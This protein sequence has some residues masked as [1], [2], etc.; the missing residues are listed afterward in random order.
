MGGVTADSRGRSKAFVVV[1]PVLLLALGLV[2]AYKVNAVPDDVVVT[3]VT[4]SAGAG[5][6]EVTLPAGSTVNDALTAAMVEPVDGRLLSA[7]T[8]RVLH[9]DLDP[10]RI[11]LDG[12]PVGRA[13]ALMAD[14]STVKVVNGRDETEKTRTVEEEVAAPPGP[15]VLRLVEERGAP[16]RVRRVVGVTSGEEVSVETVVAARA[17]A[18][19]TQKVVA[20]TFD[21]G[22]S[23]KWTPY[24][25]EILRSRGVLATFCM[26]GSAVNNAPAVAAQ[27]AAAGHQMCNHSMSHDLEMTKG[28]Q[29]RMDYELGG[30]RSAMEAAGLPAPAFFRPPGGFMSD[31]LI[32]AARA[33]GERILMWKVDTKDWQ[34][35]ATVESVLANMRQ[36]VV[37]GAII[38]LHDAGG[39]NRFTSLAVLAGLIDELKAQGYGFTFPVIDPSPTGAP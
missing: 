15:D 2:V 21:D 10:A 9:P 36:Q 38:L 1:L 37:P 8:R 16:G 28:D 6:R 34:R 25:L 20:L 35:S 13:S 3:V 30:G 7:R 12:R 24:V 19:T 23:A 27:V 5:G 18:P 33:Q 14:T 4:P 26:V 22:P 11:T 29:A 39:E 32:A 17:P 31:P